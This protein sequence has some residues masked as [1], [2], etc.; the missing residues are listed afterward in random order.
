MIQAGAAAVHYED[1]VSSE[2]KCGHMGGKVLVPTSQFIR[3]LISARLA[4][5]V[6]DIPTVIIGRTDANGATLITSDVDPRD[7]RFVTGERT[8][9]GFYKINAG[10]DTAI[11][12]GI[13]YAPYQTSSG[14]KLQPLISRKLGRSL[15]ASTE[16]T[17]TR[18]SPTTALPRLTG[19]K[20]S[21]Q[22][23]SGSSKG[24]WQEWDTSTSS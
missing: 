7:K 17:L 24:N 15:T 4:A 23:R 1:Q 8:P 19:R 12:R 20:I 9:D 2:K 11:A 21:I 16:N 18:F 13:A 5:D 22:K 10:L 14:A 3:S 6:L